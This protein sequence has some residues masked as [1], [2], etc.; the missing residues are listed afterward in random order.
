MKVIQFHIPAPDVLVV[1][2][3]DGNLYERS[4]DPKDFNSGP[5][6]QPKYVWRRVEFDLPV[7]T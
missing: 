4:R 5:G 1:L 3:E 2:A 6:H 7:H